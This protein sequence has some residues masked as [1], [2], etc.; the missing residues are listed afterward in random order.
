MRSPFQ[1]MR[2]RKL[3]E[4]LL[5]A[6][7]EA[8]L[9][10]PV[11]QPDDLESRLFAMAVPPL[12]EDEEIRYRRLMAMLHYGKKTANP[13]YE[14]LLTYGEKDYLDGYVVQQRWAQLWLDEHSGSFDHFSSH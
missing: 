12:S 7:V 4:S 13:K 1:F 10:G 8:R 6:E 9:R 5:Q 2:Q 3:R 11:Q 14:A